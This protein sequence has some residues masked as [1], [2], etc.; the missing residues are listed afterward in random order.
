M[1]RMRIIISGVTNEDETARAIEAGADAVAFEFYRDS[2]RYIDPGEAFRLLSAMPPLVGSVGV[3]R[4]P[5]LDDFCDAEEQCPTALSLFTG[6]EEE[7]LVRRCGPGVMRT[8]RWNCADLSTQLAAWADV[9][10]LDA[11]V[12]DLA[13]FPDHSKIA[14]P[15]GKYRKHVF[16]A[17]AEAPMLRMAALKLNAFGVILPITTPGLE[18]ACSAIMG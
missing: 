13:G 2:D 6:N 15:L 5:D 9:E 11:V 16:V 18:V 12:I 10:E 17:G 8:F 4:D 14:L 1:S 3:F 7:W